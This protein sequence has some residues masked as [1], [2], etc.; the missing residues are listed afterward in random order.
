MALQER[1]RDPI[2]IVTEIITEKILLNEKYLSTAQDTT[3][4]KHDGS[5]IL[6]NDLIKINIVDFFFH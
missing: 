2:I 6:L 1:D 4:S 3:E 5:F